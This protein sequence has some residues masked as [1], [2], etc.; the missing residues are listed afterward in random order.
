MTLRT[1]RAKVTGQVLTLDAALQDTV[2]AVLALLEALPAESPFLALDPLQR[3]RRT[4]EAL[5]RV[6]LRESQV[7]PLLLV[8]EDLHW[9]DTETQAVLDQLV[10]SLPTRPGAVAGQLS[11]R[12]P[13]RLGQQNVLHPTAARPPAPGERRGLAPGPPGSGREPGAS[14]PA[15]D[16]PHGGQP[17]LPGRERAHP[18]GDRRPSGRAGAYRLARPLAGLQVPATVHAVLA[19]RIDRLPPEDKRLLQTAAVI[20]TEVPFPLLHAIAEVPEEVL[21]RGLAHLQAAEF[22]Y[23]T[24]LFPERSIPS[25]MPSRTRWPTAASCRSGGVCCMRALLRCWERS[26]GTG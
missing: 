5:K 25:S 20:G 15:P 26:W 8:F 7:Q 2:P 17:L 22:L 24:R 9:I 4:L 10:E 12:V 1:V 19:A 16:G 11:P 14:H 21:H 18:G 6:L 23:E 13:A 3:R